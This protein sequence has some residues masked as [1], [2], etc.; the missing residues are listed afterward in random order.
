MLYYAIGYITVFKHIFYYILPYFAK[1][2][3]YFINGA[4][5]I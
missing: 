2:L 4:G 1:V 5:R 3:L